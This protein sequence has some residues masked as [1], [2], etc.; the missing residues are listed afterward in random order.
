ML[1]VMYRDNV[2]MGVT[3]H[4]TGCKMPPKGNPEVGRE[5]IIVKH[6]PHTGVPV[7]YSDQCTRLLAG[8]TEI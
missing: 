6:D 3:R 8:D 2:R 5:T 1:P 7:S 4:G